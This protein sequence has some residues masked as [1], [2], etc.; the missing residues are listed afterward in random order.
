[1]KFATVATGAVNGY[2]AVKL[3]EAGADVACLARGAHLEAIRR[4]G[5]KLVRGDEAWV[6][7]PRAA[8]ADPAEI[9]PVDVIL[10]AVKAQDLEA[11]APLC[12]PMMGPETVAIPF[13][14]GVEASGR[15]EAVLGEGRV[16][17]G[18][19]GISAFL[20]EPGRVEWSSPFAVVSLRGAG[21]DAVRPG[22]AIA[23]A[24]QA[25]G[26]DAEAPDD[27][28]KALW[29]KFMMLATLAG[30][31]AAGRCTAGDIQREPALTALARGSVA[32][33]A[34]L[35]RARGVEIDEA[36]EAAAWKLLAGMPEGGKASMAK[37]LD[38]GR[39]LEVEWLSGSV[40]RL[41]AEAGLEAP[42]H[43]TMNALLSP[44][45]DG[46]RAG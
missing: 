29:R 39:P 33:I 36:D 41:S 19:C 13:L 35:A 18:T 44:W 20:P 42:I 28:R 46:R 26:I 34:R 2:L 43:A 5:L 21:R 10:V 7:R 15:L 3:A 25:A 45:K 23:E 27:I 37:D 11:V 16:L 31:T 12:R 6:G 1:M 14:N 38:A 9:G 17:E 22:G 24:M 40:A 32:E 30:I 4:D 8:S